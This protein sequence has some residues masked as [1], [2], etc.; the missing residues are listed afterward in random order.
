MKPKPRFVYLSAVNGRFVSLKYYRSHPK[1][2]V[3]I[4][5][6]TVKRKLGKWRRRVN[7]RVRPRKRSTKGE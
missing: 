1:T 3:R 5:V 6:E 4:R 7:L 2:T